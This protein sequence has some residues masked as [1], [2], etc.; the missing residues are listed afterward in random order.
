MRH[1]RLYIWHAKYFWHCLAILML[2][3]FCKWVNHVDA[4][5][6]QRRVADVTAAWSSWVEFRDQ[7]CEPYEKAYAVSERSG[8]FTTVKNVVTYKCDDGILYSVSE[9]VQN[10]A[11]HCS[12][13]TECVTESDWIPKR[14]D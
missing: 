7:H 11:E 1:E 13:E 9:E 12:V 4:G 10:I 8:K 5:R 3:V 14:P 2:V 6:V